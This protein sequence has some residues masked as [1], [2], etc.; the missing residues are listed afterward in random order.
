[1]VRVQRPR[2]T[3][4]DLREISVKPFHQ[5]SMRADHGSAGYV[6]LCVSSDLAWAGDLRDVLDAGTA[7]LERRTSAC[8]GLGDCGR[9]GAVALPTDLA[10]QYSEGQAGLHPNQGSFLLHCVD[11]V[12]IP[13]S[14][15]L[16]DCGLWSGGLL[17]QSGD[18]S[19]AFSDLGPAGITCL[20]R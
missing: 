1:M 4:Q 15:L 8:A 11:S 3:D 17:D 13:E 18:L 10:E 6:D 19:L 20:D 7:P 14:A 12:L 2:D 5:K 9:G 16:S